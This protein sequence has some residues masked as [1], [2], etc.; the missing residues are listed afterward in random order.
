LLQVELPEKSL[1]VRAKFVG[2]SNRLP[3]WMDNCDVI[4]DPPHKGVNVFRP[5]SGQPL[6]LSY[7]HA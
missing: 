6:A 7:Q 5:H 4:S 1:K 2:S 3:V